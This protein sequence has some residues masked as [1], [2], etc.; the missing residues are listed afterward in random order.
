LAGISLGKK[1][2]GLLSR[3]GALNEA[4]YDE[5]EDTLIESDL[6]ARTA[7]D[8]VDSLRDSKEARGMGES[9]I[10]DYL[11][12]QLL[13]YT[14]AAKLD[15]RDK[16]RALILVLGVNGVGKTTTIA[17]MARYFHD[18][19]GKSCVLA[20]GD[21][22]RA[23]AIDQLLV[24]GER[25]GV[26]VVHQQPG[27]DPGA[28]I[29]DA[30]ESAVSRGEELVLAD[31]AGRM[32]NKANLIR[33]LQK[34]HKIVGAKIGTEN[35]CKLLVIDTTTGQNALR[36][37]ELFHEAVGVDALVMAKY[38]SAAKGGIIIPIQ[39][40]LSIPVAFVGTG[41]GYGDLALFDSESYLDSL[42]GIG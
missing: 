34:I 21:T 25:L 16:K 22:F 3:K 33:E 30:L 39:R 41:E 35:Y 29:Y 15:F 31:T 2:R 13:P 10:L 19:Q 17:K 36:Q 1:I 8:L 11:K 6:G 9:E 32:H 27:A 18:A 4:F 12:R 23:A 7:M 38:D 40:T 28:V 20:A 5:L 37:A 24:H 26:R 42:L 14:K